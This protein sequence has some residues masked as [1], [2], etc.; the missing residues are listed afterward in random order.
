M[1]QYVIRRIIISII[2]LFG[3]SIML[4]GLSRLIPSDYISMSTAT[5]QRITEEMKDH[6]RELY[7]LDKSFFGGYW[8]WLKGAVRLDFG[9]SLAYARP[10]TE[11]IGS[12][13]GV[14]F[15]ISAIALIFEIIIGIPLGILAA[16]KRNMRADYI[17]TAFVFIGISLPSFFFA[18]TLKR[19]FGFY[20]VNLLPINGL[21][22]PRVIYS[23]FSLAKLADYAAHLAL[24]VAVFVLT[25]CGAW[26][27]YTRAN[28]IEALES[29]Y[30]RTAR[31]KGV[32]E[33]RVVYTH[34]FRNTLIPIVTLLGAQLPA[35]FSGAI[36][37]EQLFAIP[38]IG[39][40]AFK[41]YE[42]ND[43]PFMM[44]FNMLLALFTIVGFL[45]SDILY[46]V[47]DPRIRLS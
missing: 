9:V 30:V 6:L 20:G 12:C 1:R 14:T 8:S 29:D 45:I 5:Q 32:P 36:I 31:A 37:T 19:I 47:A 10:V 34:A 28:M 11:V 27:R 46:A 23:G 21:L 25:N 24:P 35:L 18:A 33:Q 15:S 13:I 44:G 43:M 17:I 42:L 38:G 7:G 3:V 2:V 39:N 40:M 22:N 16:R 26:L 4:F 41:A